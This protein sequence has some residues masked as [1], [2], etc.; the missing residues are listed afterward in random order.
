M[1]VCVY[2]CASSSP[3]DISDSTALETCRI[4]LWVYVC[5]YVYVCVYMLIVI[6]LRHQ[7][8]YSTWNLPNRPMGVCMYVCMYSRAGSCLWLYGDAVCVHIHT[9]ACIHKMSISLYGKYAEK[10]FLCESVCAYIHIY[11]H[12]YIHIY[13]YIFTPIHA[14]IYTSVCAYIYIY[15]YIYTHT[16]THTYMYT[17]D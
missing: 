6:T 2:V 10:L 9:H 3:L 1:C 15:I 7:R 14:S 4:V 16:H 11:I 5:M 12:A 13:I 17:H 8:L